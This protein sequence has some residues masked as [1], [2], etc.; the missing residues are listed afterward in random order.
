VGTCVVAGHQ[1]YTSYFGCDTETSIPGI[2]ASGLHET[3][4]QSLRL[5]GYVGKRQNGQIPHE[6]VTNGEIYAVGHVG[7][8]TEFIASVWDTLHQF[9]IHIFGLAMKSSLKKCTLYARCQWI[10]FLVNRA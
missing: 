5:L 7:E 2:L 1:D 10:I 8:S 6:I 3:A 9:G 4:K